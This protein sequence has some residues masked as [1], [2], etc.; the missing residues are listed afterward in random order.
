[1]TQRGRGFDPEQFFGPEGPFGPRGPLGPGGIFGP[2]G[3]FGTSGGWPGVGGFNLGS[4][5]PGWSGERRGP[6]PG[7]RRARRGDVRSAILELL[8]ERGPSNGYQLMQGI[9][10]ATDGAWTPS[11]GAIY[12]ALAQ[13]EDEGLVEQVET[14][15]RKAYQ[16]TDAGREAA[17]NGPSLL[18]GGQTG[19]EPED[20]WSDRAERRGARGH[21]HHG[22][23]GR[24]FGGPGRH[25]GGSRRTGGT[26][27]KALGGVAMATQAVGQAG[28]DELTAEAAQVLDRARRDLYRMLAEAEVA[29]DEDEATGWTGEEGEEITD[30]EIV[31]D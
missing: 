16:L 15:G 13:L 5:G 17:G 14:E 26:L 9:A 6:R 12:P 19:Q 29:K 24:G 30:G 3:P 11:S 21:A 27:W 23:P 20:P 4:S 18:W 2:Q 22:G 25:G 1:M 31:E 7:G 8:A 10:E 28:D